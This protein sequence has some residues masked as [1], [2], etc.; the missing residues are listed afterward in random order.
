M[1]HNA[2]AGSL[3][4]ERRLNS[5]AKLGTQFLGGEQQIL[6]DFYLD[7]IFPPRD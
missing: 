3:E 4:F 2:G 1:L 6:T 5:K 7:D